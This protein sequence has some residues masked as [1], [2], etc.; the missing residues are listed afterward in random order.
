MVKSQPEV[1]LVHCM[2]VY[3]RMYVC[4][5]VFMYVCTALSRASAHGR[6]QLKHQ[7]FKVGWLH[8]AKSAASGY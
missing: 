8:N 1:V 5:Y 2:Y 6:V 3:I 7:K 4:M